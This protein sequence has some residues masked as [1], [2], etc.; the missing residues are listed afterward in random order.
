MK[1]FVFYTHINSGNR[2][3]E[4]IVRSTIPLISTA[5]DS[6]TIITEDYA[7]DAK[8]GLEEIATLQ[9]TRT[10]SG[11]KGI[12]SI[13]PRALTKTGI[14]KNASIMYRY[15]K[16]IRTID[17]D[18]IAISTGGDLYCYPDYQWLS[19]LSDEVN[20]RKSTNVLWGCT[21]DMNKCRSEL[22][23]ALN[24][25]DVITVR[26]YLTY[27]QM[28][29]NNI[30]AH[31]EYF[32]DTAFLLNK[33]EWDFSEYTTDREFIGINISNFVASN[34]SFMRAIKKFIDY[35]LKATSFSI[36]LVP[37]V[38]WGQQNDIVEAE[39]IKQMFLH[40][41]RV[42]VVKKFLNCCELKYLISKCSYYMGARTHT[43]I[44]AY[45]SL[46]PSIAFGYS[47][48]SKSIANDIG[49][50]EKFIIDT[51]QEVDEDK[52]IHIFEELR[53][54]SMYDTLKTSIPN[55]QDKVRRSS[56]LL[57]SL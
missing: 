26:D 21:V 57:T 37:H 53:S 34:S 39:K 49:V 19:Y 42:R 31:I 24:K 30:N 4:A 22:V 10:I 32:P 8:C 17:K 18:A 45:S 14:K 50:D 48:K 35:C 20:K 33:K 36:V 47:I 43:M 3:C 40:E 12:V 54:A 52:L 55:I 56:D 29:K 11:I 5:R 15:G 13:L 28:K 38:F 6:I 51:K 27:E 41:D 46:V 2:G 9:P 25:Y 1:N 16:A 23:E 7:L 44:A